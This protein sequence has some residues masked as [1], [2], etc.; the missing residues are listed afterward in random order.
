MWVCSSSLS[1]TLPSALCFLLPEVR[2]PPPRVGFIHRR[3]NFRTVLFI[4]FC[5]DES[6]YWN[7]LTGL[8]WEQVQRTLL[9]MNRP[10]CPLFAGDAEMQRLHEARAGPVFCLFHKSTFARMLWSPFPKT[11]PRHLARFATTSPSDQPKCPTQM[12]WT[13]SWSVWHLH[14]PPTGLPLSSL[15]PLARR[16]SP[17]SALVA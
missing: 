8:C 17:P 16:L 1:V 10:A 5:D 13:H 12:V 15:A 7:F 11:I 14:S 9:T 3:M 4:D 2:S 6:R